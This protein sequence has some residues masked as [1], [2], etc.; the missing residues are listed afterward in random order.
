MS[1]CVCLCMCVCVSIRACTYGG[2]K[3]TWGVFINHSPPYLYFHLFY[4]FVGAVWTHMSAEDQSLLA[5]F[6]CSLLVGPRNQTRVIGLGSGSL[7]LLSHLTV[8]LPSLRKGLPLNQ[9][10]SGRLMASQSPGPACL[11]T[12]LPPN[13]CPACDC[14]KPRPGHHASTGSP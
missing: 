1:V 5:L 9:S 3:L 4:F 6:V 14:R 2:Q 12:H 7:F 8:T 13:T 11:C 10:S